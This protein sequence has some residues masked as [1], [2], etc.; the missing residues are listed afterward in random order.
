MTCFLAKWLKQEA[1]FDTLLFPYRERADHIMVKMNAFLLLTCILLIPIRDSYGAVLLIGLPTLLLSYL[2]AKKFNGMLTTRLFMG[3]SF[4]VFTG[5]IIHQTGG[6]IEAHFSAFG[7][8]AILLYYRDWRVIVT[9]TLVIFLH[10][11]I[12]GYAQTLGI[13][14]YVFDDTHFWQLFLIH[15]TYFLP[16]IGM[17]V[18]LSIW[19]R[20]EGYEDQHV[21]SMAQEIIQGNLIPSIALPD[22]IEQLPLIRSVIMMKNRLLD[23][24][25]VIPVPAAVI[26]M[27]TETLVNINDAWQKKM[28][29]SKIG[30]PVKDTLIGSTPQ[31]W[32]ALLTALSQKGSN[33]LEKAE[34]SLIH[35]SG[36]P[37]LCEVSLILH[38]DA[39]P[40]MAILTMEDITEKRANE[41]RIKQLAHY[42]FL[43]GLANRTQLHDQI[44]ESFQALTNKQHAFAVMMLDLDGFK[45]VNDQYGHDAGDE[46]LKIIAQ[47]LVTVC[48]ASDVVAR[49]GGDEFVV[50]LKNCDHLS[51]A[52]ELAQRILDK[53]SQP[54]QLRG[55]TNQTVQIGVSIG[56]TH[57][58]LGA[59]N[60][61]DI[62]KQADLAVYMA[63]TAGKCQFKVFS[64][65]PDA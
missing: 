17:M 60:E 49:L 61:E 18:Y 32:E 29:V 27:D 56:I 43:T 48:R 9:A 57:S 5:L 21:L 7:L 20:R 59:T 36:H 31:A 12:L 30:V 8:I 50:L 28:G 11:L 38:E 45:P 24:L 46:V 23:L 2:F 35:P 34:V 16:F 52:E 15:V 33:L 54:I 51:K 13:P 1:N 53:M 3:S 41:E 26:R 40:V 25:H 63:K 44:N 10:H 37:I 14:I 39:H 64:A 47:R 4:M 58:D 62:L 19:L 42:D 65:S 6:D 55:S 22:N